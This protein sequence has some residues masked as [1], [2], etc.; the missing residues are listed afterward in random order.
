M[1]Q[2][3]SLFAKRLH[4]D[5]GTF[6]HRDLF[7]AAELDLFGLALVGPSSVSCVQTKTFV[8]AGAVCFPRYPSEQVTTVQT[9]AVFGI[10]SVFSAVTCATRVDSVVSE[11]IHKH[12]QTNEHDTNR[13]HCFEVFKRKEGCRGAEAMS[14]PPKR[15]QNSSLRR[16]NPGQVQRV[17]RLGLL[18]RHTGRHP[19]SLLP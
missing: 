8:V 16:Y 19:E 12:Q 9:G 6:G 3:A 2:E 15:M 10:G 14:Q 4:H 1:H 7:V 17:D 18:S 5:K 11:P 13:P